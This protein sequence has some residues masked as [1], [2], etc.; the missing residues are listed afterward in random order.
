VFFPLD[1]HAKYTVFRLKLPTDIQ[2]QLH[3]RVVTMG[4]LKLASVLLLTMMLEHAGLAL[5]HKT[6]A[7][8]SD[9]TPTLGWVW[10]MT[11]EQSKIAG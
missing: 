8:W 4:N 9:N 6:V 11:T 7:I 3:A 10:R 5:R 1:S 2:R